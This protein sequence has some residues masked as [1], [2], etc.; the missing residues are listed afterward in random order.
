MPPKSKPT[1]TWMDAQQYGSLSKEDK[2]DVAAAVEAYEIEVAA[3]EKKLAG[4]I[5]G[6]TDGKL[7]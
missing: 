5:A 6:I 2:D 7:S 3:A 4:K 1:E